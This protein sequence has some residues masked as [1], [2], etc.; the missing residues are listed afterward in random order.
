[1]YGMVWYGM[2]FQY[3][4]TPIHRRINRLD[5]VKYF[6]GIGVDIDVRGKVSSHTLFAELLTLSLYYSDYE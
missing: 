5:I 4:S 1:M 2:F 3:G 6:I